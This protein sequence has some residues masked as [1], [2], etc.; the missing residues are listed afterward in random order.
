MIPQEQIDQIKERLDIVN[1]VSDYVGL[2]SAGRN[3]QG[4]CPFHSEKTPSFVVSRE[5]QIFHC[6]GCG[7]GGNVFNFLM[8]FQNLDFLEAVEKLADKAGVTLNRLK[9]PYDKNK[10]NHEAQLLKLNKLG[11]S[12][13]HEY[14]CQSKEAEVARQYFKSRGLSQETINKFK[15]GLAP[16]AWEGLKNQLL[17]HKA[18]LSLM[19]EVGL[20]TGSQKIYDYFRNRIIFPIFNVDS[21]IIGFGART[22]DPKGSPKYLNSRDSSIYSKSRSLYG[23][24]VAKNAIAKEDVVYVVEGYFDVLALME[25][26]IENVV[27]PLGTALTSDHIKCLK[28]YTKKIVLI[29]DSDTAGINATKRTLKLFLEEN[30]EG[31]VVTLPK[32]QD[33]DEFVAEKGKEGFLSYVS[34]AKDQVYY[35][36]DSLMEQHEKSIQGKIKVL[37]ELMPILSTINH[38]LEKSLYIKEIAERL[39][40]EEKM[41]YQF[42]KTNKAAPQKMPISPLSKELVFNRSEKYI[43]QAMLAD[44]KWVSFVQ[45]ADVLDLM[46]HAELREIAQH[47]LADPLKVLQNTS[48]PSL[49][50]RLSMEVQSVEL[51]EKM[52]SDC[53]NKVRAHYLNMM[54]KDLLEQLR[55]EDDPKLLKA[56]QNLVFQQK[57][58]KGGN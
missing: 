5:K 15:L 31:R 13:Y 44:A 41:L 14:L 56:Y 40:L 53:C 9:T 45:E 54:Q 51:D 12:F 28:R 18:P 58:L 16:D 39:S 8:K 29:F 1:V 25:K 26:G 37:E 48:Y 7:V 22:L 55:R 4:L 35:L 50:T 6:F 10:K 2:K 36:L 33:P 43:I 52:L 11:A 42:L 57:K 47:I 3:F 17:K 46:T 19:L 34:K 27:A 21:E 20:V 30:V 38:P 24:H 49:V 32:N 23:I